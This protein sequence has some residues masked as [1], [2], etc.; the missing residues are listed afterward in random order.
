MFA[1]RDQPMNI[2]VINDMKEEKEQRVR[3]IQRLTAK[4][5]VKRYYVNKDL[6]K[7]VAIQTDA[8]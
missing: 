2:G 6:N 1:D 7:H 4:R 8:D 3:D 5:I